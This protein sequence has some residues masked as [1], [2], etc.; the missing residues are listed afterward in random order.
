[1]QSYYLA[2]IWDKNLVKLP[3]TCKKAKPSDTEIVSNLPVIHVF[4]AR[5]RNAIFD[6]TFVLSPFVKIN[7]LLNPFEKIDVLCRWFDHRLAST[8]LSLIV[9]M[10]KATFDMN[11]SGEVVSNIQK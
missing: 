5:Y 10:S 11:Y 9:D 4:D 2:D 7:N 3:Y 6:G 1:M 8:G